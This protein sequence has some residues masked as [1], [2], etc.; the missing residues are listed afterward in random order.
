ME[1]EAFT[2]FSLIPGVGHLPIHVVTSVF[3]LSLLFVLSLSAKKSLTRSS[4]PL[5][6]DS[7]PTPRHVFEVVIESVLD[8]MR[9]II[10][11]HSEKYL[12]LIGGLF[13]YIFMC[14]ILGILPGFLP[15]TDNINTNAA[16]A[17]VVFILYN[18]YGFR[19]HGP[20]Y[21]R[22]FAG[23]V[24]WLAPLMLIIE[25]FSHIFRPIS[26]SI[27]LFGNI[28]G[29]HTVFSIFSDLTYLVIPCAFMALGIIVSLVQAVVFALLSSVYIAL[30]VSHEH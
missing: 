8:L 20:G 2:W 5:V 19:E 28:F 18:Y 3:V 21:L 4:N 22:Q 16:C 11:P 17:L 15:P 10:G 14:N 12:P 30:A 25:F 7:S 6:P 9:T 13:I 24:L 1:H 27:R 26:L 23:P 29:D